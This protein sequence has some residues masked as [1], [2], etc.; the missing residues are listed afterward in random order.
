VQFNAVCL[1]LCAWAVA[2]FSWG[3]A[4]ARSLSI[5]GSPKGITRLDLVGAALFCL[6]LLF[7]QIALYYAPAVFCYLLGRCLVTGKIAYI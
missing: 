4:E 3:D 2:F 1:G 6:A 5:D 7:K